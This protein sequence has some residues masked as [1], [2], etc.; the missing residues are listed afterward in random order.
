MERFPGL[1]Q[2]SLDAFLK[3]LYDGLTGYV[4]VG[5]LQTNGEKQWVEHSPYRWPQDRDAIR[6]HI[7]LSSKNTDVYIT[8]AVFKAPAATKD[9]FH[10]SNV[11]WAEFDGPGSEPQAALSGLPTLASLTIESSPGRS[12]RYYRLETACSD[13]TTLENANRSLAYGLGADKSGWNANK[14]L[15]PLQSTNHK[16]NTPHKLRLVGSNLEAEYTV[17]AL[18]E[19]YQAPKTTEAYVPDVLIPVTDIILRYPFNENARDLMKTKKLVEGHD[20][21]GALVSLAYSLAEMGLTTVEIFSVLKHKDTQWVVYANRADQHRRLAEIVQIA[22][23]KYPNG[24]EEEVQPA[25]PGADFLVLGWRSLKEYV[26]NY[27]WV[28][29]DMWLKDTMNV[30]AGKAGVG[31][32]QLSLRFGQ[33]LALGRPDYL[34]YKIPSQRKVLFLSLEL[35]VGGIKFFQDT[36]WPS[37]TEDEIDV[38]E[39]QLI[40]VPVGN[41]V[42]LASQWG[43]EAVNYLIEQYEPDVLMTDSMGSSVAG[44]L[45]KSELTSE[46]LA[47]NDRLNSRGIS[48]WFISHPRKWEVSQS[49]RKRP[50]LDDLFGDVYIGNRARGVFALY[51][52]NKED[53]LELINLKQSFTKDKRSRFL[54]RDEHLDFHLTD[55]PAVKQKSAGDTDGVTL[56][57]HMGAQDQAV[58]HNNDAESI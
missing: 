51:D 25:A 47:Y 50:T 24:V 38:L 40:V 15:R 41:T 6:S 3:F 2:G 19:A 23:D 29:E 54:L 13:S 39:Q 36:M 28:A 42:N 46:L 35:G 10:A 37:F 57:E 48:T 17:L 5:E 43:Q 49:A 20:W 1:E 21:S 27:E 9:A 22:K 56:A 18:G 53:K 7:V 55:P 14:L 11:A 32:T 8:P 4:I 58:P 26:V 16:Y 52:T 31:K 34:G 12:H 33:A 45:A 44:S 30:M